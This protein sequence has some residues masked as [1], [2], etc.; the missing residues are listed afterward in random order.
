MKALV[1][2]IVLDLHEL[3][4]LVIWGCVVSGYIQISNKLGMNYLLGSV[5]LVNHGGPLD[6]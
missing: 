1:P 2:E 6:D 3:F 5:H 4:I